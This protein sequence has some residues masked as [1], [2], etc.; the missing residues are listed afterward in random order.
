MT[1]NK[2]Y[3][4]A[5]LLERT[6]LDRLIDVI[7][8]RLGD[9]P[10]TSSHDH[11]EVFLSDKRCLEKHTVD[12]VLKLD[13]SPNSKIQRLLITCCTSTEGAGRPEHEIQVDFDG[14][15]IDKVRAKVIVSVRSDDARWNDIENKLDL[16]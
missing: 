11:F 7:H 12:D 16:A 4:R 3:G 5:F 14:R 9:H 8:A 2:P 15:M 13:N 6:K 10:H 1:T